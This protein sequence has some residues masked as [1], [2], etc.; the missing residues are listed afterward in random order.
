[1]ASVLLLAKQL[2]RA[3]PVAR[4][5]C[6]LQCVRQ[7]AA[8]SAVQSTHPHAGEPDECVM[9]SDWIGPPHNVSHLRLVKFNAPADESSREK[10]FR[11]KRQDTQ[12]W[13]H[14]YWS[15]HNR[16]FALSKKAFLAEKMENMSATADITEAL[17]ADEMA[18]FYKKYL[19][20]NKE[21]HMQFNR[22]WYRRQVALLWPAL[23]VTIERFLWRRRS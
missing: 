10:A 13:C 8:P 23:C 12:E 15:A 19:D 9:K 22:E 5:H 21:A 11:L 6:Q 18:E 1:M 16:N 14:R 20:D 7:F 3:V 2:C 4:E 17:S